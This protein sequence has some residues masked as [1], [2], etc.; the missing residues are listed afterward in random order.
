VLLPE[1]ATSTRWENNDKPQLVQMIPQKLPGAT[2][3]YNNAQGSADTQLSR[4]QADLAQGDCM[5]VVAPVDS[6]ASAQIVAAAK[7]QNVPVISYDRLIESRD[8]AYYVSF[9]NETVGK[10]QGQYIADHYKDL[11]CSAP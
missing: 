7:A 1:T 5:L 9:N 4:A 3:D 11:G 8:L 2:V 6:V 10:I